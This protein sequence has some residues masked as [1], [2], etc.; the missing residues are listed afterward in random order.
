[1]VEHRLW[2]AIAV[3]FMIVVAAASGALVKLIEP[4]LDIA[5]A[6]KN[7]TWVWIAAAGFFAISVIRG[8]ANFAQ[9]VA[10]Q[11][12]GLRVIEKMQNQMFHS[13]LH[14]EIEYLE[15]EGTARQLSRFTSDCYFLRDAITKVFTGSGRDTLVLLSM[16]GLMLQ[17]NLKLAILALIFFPI[18]VLPIAR[19]GRRLRKVADK[20]QMEFGQMTSVLDDSL[21]NARQVRAYSMQEHEAKRGNEA[22]N[23]TYLLLLKAVRT[24][25]LTHPIMD[26]L[27]GATLFTIVLFGGYQILEGE[28]TVGSFMA[29]FT[30]VFMAYQPMRS[31]AGLYN[32]L[33][34]GLAAAARNF[35]VIDYDPKIKDA[36]DAIPLTDG[37]GAVTLD[38]VTFS[39]DGETPVLNAVDIDIAA[40]ETVALVGPSGA[41]KTT[42]LNLIPRFYDA[43]DGKVMIDGQD[44]AGATLQSVMSRIALVSQEPALFND[45]IRANIAYGRWGA[46]QEDIEQAARNA[47]AHDFIMDLPDGYD[48]MVGEQGLRLS[49]GQ[50]QRIAIARAMLKDAPILLLDEAT[51]ALD[52]ESEQV[53]QAAL[54]RLMVG[55]TTVVIAHRLATVR[56][57]D[58]I[59]VMDKGR[60]VEIGTHAEL[61]RKD[62]LY[63]RLSRIQFDDGLSATTLSDGAS[64][65][66]AG[67]N[68]APDEHQ[69]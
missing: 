32:S 30:A 15:R 14:I 8:G 60:V 46:P 33:Q 37:P 68:A 13:L 61:S 41:G 2:I 35:S 55:R 36:P 40:G 5:F 31:L 18:S 63:A 25:A 69:A 59:F 20:T 23:I 9:S 10:M 57:A 22:F 29:F 48:T 56:K 19:I 49:G 28:Q 66:G 44:V 4:A 7:E 67:D 6:E 3:F 53:V 50:R 1:M 52:A 58:R 24:R 11:K 65:A 64:T 38:R 16:I 43:V 45:T 54:A 12:V 51:S 62:G 39:Y 34:E 17:T 21:K 27:A 42:V 26:S 47:A